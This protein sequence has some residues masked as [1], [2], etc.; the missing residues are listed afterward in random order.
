MDHLH[1]S[2]E[3]LLNKTL[4]NLNLHFIVRCHN[5]VIYYNFRSFHRLMMVH[6]DG[7]VWFTYSNMK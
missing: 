6:R 4:V 7:D 2:A 5:H 3:K 1:D